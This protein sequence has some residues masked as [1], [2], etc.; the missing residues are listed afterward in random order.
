MN[1]SLLDN[2]EVDEVEDVDD[3][4]D[5]IEYIDVSLNVDFPFNNIPLYSY[6]ATEKINKVLSKNQYVKEGYKAEI[7][8][9]DSIIVN[10][11]FNAQATVENFCDLLVRM[12]FPPSFQRNENNNAYNVK[13]MINGFDEPYLSCNV[14]FNPDTGCKVL[15]ID[16]YYIFLWFITYYYPDSIK[17][18]KILETFVRSYMAYQID[19]FDYTNVVTLMNYH[20]GYEIA[21]SNIVKPDG[22][23]VLKKCDNVFDDW[24]DECHCF[25]EGLARVKKDDKWNF[26]DIDGKLLF[27]RFKSFVVDGDFHEGYAVIRKKK[28]SGKYNFIGKDGNLLFNKWYPCLTDFNEGFSVVG[29][30]NGLSYIGKDEKFIN[31]DLSFSCTSPFVNGYANAYLSG[32]FVYVD[33][34]GN[35]M[36]KQGIYSISSSEYFYDGFAIVDLKDAKHNFIDTKGKLLSEDKF[37]ECVRFSEGFARVRTGKKWNYIRT[38]GKLLFP[39]N[40]DIQMCGDFHEGFAFVAIKDKHNGKLNWNYVDKNGNFLLVGDYAELYKCSDFKDGLALVVVSDKKYNYLTTK[41]ELVFEEGFSHTSEVVKYSDYLICD[42]GLGSC[43][44]SDK[45]IIAFI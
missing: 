30:E 31:K 34:S 29:I 28:G 10:F 16:E 21:V 14:G 27:K 25:A 43:V 17:D 33:T 5:E 24:F 19:R 7:D 15:L 8:M 18:N 3:E 23:F 13:V 44:G 45:N 41:G 42:Y 40:T 22:S 11:Q 20:T 6:Y 38:N 32:S 4:V 35:I 2:V 39:K 12:V 37:D 9:Y 1:E 26:I 36:K